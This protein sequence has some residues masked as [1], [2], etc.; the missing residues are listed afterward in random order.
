MKKLILTC[1]I[2]GLACSTSKAQ[3]FLYSYNQKM[4]DVILEDVFSPPVASRI[5]VYAHIAAYE[6]LA[7]QNSQLKSMAGQVQALTAMPNFDKPFERTIAARV[8]FAT[9]VKKMVYSEH[10]IDEFVNQDKTTWDKISTDK[11]AIQNSEELGN[12]IA[13]HIIKWFQNDNYV[14]T[15]TLRRYE[16]VDSLGA[17]QPTAPDY[18]NGLEPNWYLMRSFVKVSSYNQK[19]PAP[20]VY[21]E[22]KKSTYYKQVAQLLSQHRKLDSAQINTALYWDDNPKT[23]FSKGHL[24]YFIHKVTPGGHWL[25][26]AAQTMQ[27]AQY[28]DEQAAR[29]FTLASIAEYEAFKSCWATK[30]KYNTVRPETYIHR[31]MDKN[32]R[33]LIETPPFPEYPSGHSMVSSAMATVLTQFIPIKNGFTDSS[34]VY[35]AIEPRYFKSFNDAAKQASISRFYGGIHY[36]PALDNGAKQGALIAQSILNQINT[37]PKYLSIVVLWSINGNAQKFSILNPE[38]TGI[39]FKNLLNENKEF[40]LYT[41]EYMYI[42]TGVALGDINNDGLLDIY[43]SGAMEPNKLYLNEGNFKFKDITKQAGVEAD[44]GIGTGVNMVDINN[45]GYLD[46]YVC[47]DGSADAAQRRNL[48]YIN[49]KNNTFTEQAAEYGIADSSYSIQSYFYDMDLDGDLDLFLV[50]H[51]GSLKDAKKINLEYNKKGELQAVKNG[52]RQYVSY[53]FYEQIKGKFID[54]T[55]AAGLDNHAFGLS[56]VIDDFNEDGYP[57]IYVANDYTLPDVLYINNKNGTYTDKIDDYVKHMCYNSMGSDYADINNDGKS[58]LFVVDMLP[59][60]NERQ[61]LLKQMMSYDQLNKLVKYG[62]KAQFVKNVLQVNNGNKT[63]SDVSYYSGMAF[64]DWSWAPL[65]ADFNNDGLK[66]VYITNGYLRD[67]VNM[68]YSNFQMDSVIRQLNK[69]GQGGSV[70]SVLSTIPSVPLSNY[71]YLN[72]GNLKFTNKTVESGLNVPSMS[73]GAAYGDLDNDGDLDIVVSNLNQAAFV[74]Q[75]LHNESDSANNYVRF[76][77]KAKN[78]TNAFGT[79]IKVSSNGQSQYITYMPTKGYMSNHEQAAHF[80]LGKNKTFDLLIQFTDG[81][82]ITRESLAANAT[83]N[84]KQEDAEKVV[85]TLIPAIPT[86]NW[87]NITTQCNLAITPKENEFIDF[88]QEPILPKRCSQFGPCMAVGDV[89]KDGLDDVFIGGAAAHE[90]N[91]FLQNANGKFSKSNQE[92]FVLDKIYEDV[93]AQFFDADNDNDLDLIVLSGGND[94]PK[95]L[96]KYPIRLYLNNKGVFSKASTAQ[97]PKIN[98]SAKGLAIAD[99]N[100]DGFQDVFVGGRLMPGDYGKIPTSYLLLNN[101]GNF[102]ESEIPKRLAQAGMVSGARFFDYNK[103]GFPDLFLVGDWMSPLIF[104]N[105]NGKYGEG[106]NELDGL[107]G[108]WNCIHFVDL[109]NDGNDEIIMGNNGDNTRYKASKS[110][111]LTILVNDFDKNGSTD[112][113]VGFMEDGKNYPYALRDNMLDQM[114]YLKKKYTRYAPYAKATILDIFTKEQLDQS[115]FAVAKHMKTTLG[116]NRGGGNFAFKNMPYETQLMPIQSIVNFKAK[117][118][119]NYLLLVGNDYSTELESGRNDA[120]IGVLYEVDSNSDLI[121]MPMNINID[122][123]VRQILPIQIAGKPCFIIAQNSGPIRVITEE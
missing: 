70:A 100:K 90:A 72:N 78:G 1:W 33:P 50:N 13:Q 76:K 43:F 20:S 45:D 89:N 48:L 5:H 109:N 119:K 38:N 123:D 31:F 57:D 85:K 24:S 106:I 122:G 115:A 58:D 35:L 54:K 40:N 32:F 53:R 80:G 9:V 22:R 111:P 71:L 114:V 91:L 29:V 44:Y 93:N 74:M 67:F 103:D 47:K 99:I 108:W 49:N 104:T 27:A 96:S 110:S 121:K 6:A 97:F 11:V 59:E 68:D 118:Q 18:A 94:Y 79:K 2:I 82:T 42:G 92:V 23:N 26:I 39:Q 41:Y 19:M 113:V 86:F 73:N 55:M 61:K 66:D 120:G 8:A 63:Y 46:I 65:I 87:K 17:W 105:N 117:N 88:K 3:S 21:S 84:I 116:I 16:V 15:R 98:V 77:I 60:T 81:T 51:P 83:Y 69:I 75:N 107:Q 14:Y 12:L 30:Y 95:D 52:E 4:L 7:Y 37:F 102:T 28:N 10:L 34:Q 112:C 25:K 56:A 64:T 62:L 36:M 101:N